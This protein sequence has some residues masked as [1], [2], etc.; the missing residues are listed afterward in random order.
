MEVSKFLDSILKFSDWKDI[1]KVLLEMGQENRTN[2]GI[3][4]G[5]WRMP[6]YA[7]PKAYQSKS[8]VTHQA[9]EFGCQVC[10]CERV[11]P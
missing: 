8:F 6:C 9:F 3:Y 7:K 5:D 10:F 2:F 4:T 1:G 11:S